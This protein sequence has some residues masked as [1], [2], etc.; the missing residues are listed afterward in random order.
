MKI[1]VMGAGVIGVT[2]AYFLARDGHEVTVIDRQPIPANETSF[3][4]AGGIAPGH[5]YAWASPQVPMILLRSLWRND[6]AFR[7]RF[8]P[9]PHMWAWC[10]RFLGQCTAEKA[11]LNTTRKLRLCAYSQRVLNAVV[12]HTGVQYDRQTNGYL[13]L[14]RTPE[15]LARGVAKTEVLAAGGQTFEVVDRERA[16]RIDPALAPV[17]EK[18]AGGIFCPTDESGDVHKFTNG[19]A[20]YCKAELGVR[21]AMETT[22]RGIDVAG[23]RVE[24]V[25]TDKAD[26]RA[27]LYVLSLGSYSPVV[28]R[29]IGVHLPIYPVKGY[30]VTLPIAPEHTAPAIG[31]VDE[32]NLVAFTRMGNRFRLT[33]TAEFAGYETTYR[34]SDFTAMLRAARDLFPNAGNYD[35]PLYWAGLRPMTPEGTPIFGYGR[36]KNLFMNTGH[37][38]VGWTMACGSGR[39]TADLV[40]GRPA[41]IDLDGMMMH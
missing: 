38:H 6:Q 18:F 7:L 13:Y 23:D 20:D 10:V 30:S 19:L 39:I 36:H 40:A 31:G 17:K 1:V 37:G 15:S 41:E 3:A 35:K 4:N 24:R 11:R 12:Q 21:F 26:Y 2:S 14:Y 33:A 9:D 32:D 5:S 8:K 29:R 34:P 22:I 27:D 25:V 28:A 16:A